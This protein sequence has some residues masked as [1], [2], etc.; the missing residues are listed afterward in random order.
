MDD[1]SMVPSP[2]KGKRR[3]KTKPTKTTAKKTNARVSKSPSLKLDATN[4][5]RQDEGTHVEMSG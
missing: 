1:E 4:K 5:R 3:S 2:D